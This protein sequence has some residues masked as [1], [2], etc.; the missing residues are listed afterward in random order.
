[1]FVW[2]VLWI[3]IAIIIFSNGTPVVLKYLEMQDATNV[4][5]NALTW[6][7]VGVAF[8]VSLCMNTFLLRYL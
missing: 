4:M 7:K 2:G 6:N 5:H 3:N 8:A 1:M